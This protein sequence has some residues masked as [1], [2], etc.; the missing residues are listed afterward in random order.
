[1]WK[2][3]VRSGYRFAVRAFLRKGFPEGYGKELLM[4]MRRRPIRCTVRALT[5]CL[6]VNTGHC[7]FS[8]GNGIQ[9]KDGISSLGTDAVL[10]GTSDNEVDNQRF[11]IRDG[12][13]LDI[14]EDV[15]DLE[16]PSEKK[17]EI[18]RGRLVNIPNV[19]FYSMPGARSFVRAAEMIQNRLSEVR[20]GC[21]LFFP[22][23]PVKEWTVG[24]RNLPHMRTG[25][26]VNILSDEERKSF[27]GEAESVKRIPSGRSELLTV[28]PGVP[29]EMI[30]RLRFL[31]DR[32]VLLFKISPGL[33][34]TQTRVHD[35][36]AIQDN[37]DKQVYL[38]PH[39]SRFRIVS[40]R[41]HHT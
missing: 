32:K 23:L 8:L 36:A 22:R 13:L 14:T 11:V 21:W 35:L 9:V 41:G 34:R 3:E 37:V 25:L 4:R 17:A 12:E 33:R 39:R 24:A 18:R 2:H 31:A 7:E 16:L 20:N 26:D 15:H 29:I 28:F 19:R 6:E 27:L 30:S 5:P 38:I 10:P 40:L 1:M